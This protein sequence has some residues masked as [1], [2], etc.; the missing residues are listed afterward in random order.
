M[1]SL[2]EILSA[3]PVA[4]INFQTGRVLYGTYDPEDET[5]FHTGW[6]YGGPGDPNTGYFFLDGAS[7]EAEAHDASDA[8]MLEH[9]YKRVT[10][11]TVVCDGP[12]SSECYIV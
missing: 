10:P 2:F 6:F 9:G 4:N 5:G 8:L 11:W 7:T 3:V 1:P 12:A